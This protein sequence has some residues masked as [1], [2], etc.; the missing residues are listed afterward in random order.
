MPDLKEVLEKFNSRL[1]YRKYDKD[2]LDISRS[3]AAGNLGDDKNYAEWAAITNDPLVIAN[4]VK[5][6]IT[7]LVSKLSS[8]PFRPEKQKLME[9]GM[10]VRLNSIF[11]DTYQDVLSDGY[12]Y[13]AVGMKNGKPVIKPVDSR[14]ILFN[15]DHPTLCDSTDIIVFEIVPLPMDADNKEIVKSDFIGSYVD[16]DPETE[17]VRVT[18]YHKTKDGIVM[19][20]YD[21]DYTKP[22]SLPLKN[23]DRIPVVRFV[24]ER[25]ELND[26]RYH[27]R[28]IYYMMASVLKALALTGTKINSRTAA[29]DD[30]NYIVRQDAISNEN[31]TWKNS[32]V[33]EIANV[34][35][36]GNDIPV[37]QFVPHDNEF[38]MNAFNNWKG[39]IADMLGPTVAS[40]SEAVTR[41]EVIARNEVKDAISNTYL[42]RM[43]DSIEEVYRVIQMYSDG[44]TSEVIIVGGYIDSVKKQK[45]IGQL[46]NLYQYAK[47]GGLNTQGF[48]TQMLS[49]T[50]L[51]SQV[52]EALAVTFQQDPFKSPQVQQLEQTVQQLNQTIQ[53]QNTQIALLR[54]QATQRLERQKEF[55]DSTER[56]KR[57]ELAYKQ[58]SDEAKQTQEALMEVLKDCLAKADYDGAIAVMEQIKQQ[59]N[60]II[61]DKIINFAANA[62]TEENNQSVQNALAETS[63]PAAP[64]APVQG[65]API[66]PQPNFRQVVPNQQQI[67]QNGNA[68]APMPRPAVTPFNDA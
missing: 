68:T 20:F 38:L 12:A 41:E 30:A 49:L 67:K 57:L 4:Y 13:L 54:L 46:V 11:T 65:P 3:L 44:D 17:R 8:A 24:G 29:S 25:V 2:A 37:V 66:S 7:T 55:I 34:D 19:D 42:S 36:N 28:G 31:T 14:Y 21:E 39:V 60:P 33:K 52:K 51:P 10:S 26:K 32:G 9:L 5:T 18:H 61:T 58:W 40:G 48:V 22:T 53:N 6:Y 16:Y 35:Q 63:Q 59:S 47:E 1:N 15:G 64:T 50:D 45:D 23:L 43:A 56:T 27:Y 62:F